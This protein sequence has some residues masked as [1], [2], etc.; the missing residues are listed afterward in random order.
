[1]YV[2]LNQ[3]LDLRENVE[4]GLISAVIYTTAEIKPE[5]VWA[6]GANRF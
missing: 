3:K 2:N 5:I 6:E 4:S 1:V